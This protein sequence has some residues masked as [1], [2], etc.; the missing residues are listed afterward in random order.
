MTDTPTAD[1]QAALD[2][3]NAKAKELND[4]LKTLASDGMDGL[5]HNLTSAR[6]HGAGA[7]ATQAA[8]QTAVQALAAFLKQETNAG[9]A[10]A[11]ARPLTQGA[12]GADDGITVIINNNA[13]AS[14]T[15]SRSTD[16]FDK[17]TLEITIDQMVA[18]S[19]MRGRETSGVL[20]TLFGIVPSLIGR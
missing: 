17:K 1:L 19:L 18:A 9:M 11:L 10:Q 15:A 13:Q 5:A 6:G 14:V 12:F 20:R 2:A 16:A 7:N 8:G 3:V 4:T